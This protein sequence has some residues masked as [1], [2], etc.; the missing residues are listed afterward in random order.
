MGKGG[1]GEGM[2]RGGGMGRKGGE[3]EEEGAGGQGDNGGIRSVQG[4]TGCVL[5]MLQQ[6]GEGG[7]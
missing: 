1:K 5:N 2:R 6:E 3:I 7:Q 4:G